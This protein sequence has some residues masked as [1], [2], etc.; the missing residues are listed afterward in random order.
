[1]DRHR[2]EKEKI[3]MVEKKYFPSIEIQTKEGAF[4]A[5][6]GLKMVAL[7]KASLIANEHQMKRGRR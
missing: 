4:E 6:C 1:M 5:V 7:L 2:L 3:L